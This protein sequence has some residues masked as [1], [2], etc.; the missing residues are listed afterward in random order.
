MKEIETK[1]KIEH[2]GKVRKK[3]RKIGAKFI[4]KRLEKDLYLRQGGTSLKNLTIRLRSLGR[5]KSIFTLKYPYDNKEQGIFKIMKERETEVS[6]TK[7]F[8]KALAGLGI[9]PWFSKEKVRETY[10]LGPAKILIDKLPHMGYYVE[11]EASSIS[12]VRKTAAKLGLD[13][14]KGTSENYKALFERYKKLAK[15][16]HAALTFS[17]QPY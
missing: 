15:K 2:P 17:M 8:L 12:G 13:V 11:I 7:G 1:F 9:K 6:D 14:Q 4:S 10:V 3:L 5:K 16:P